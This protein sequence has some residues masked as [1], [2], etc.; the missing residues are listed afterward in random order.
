MASPKVSVII[1]SYNCE[2]FIEETIRSVIAQTF[3]DWELIVVDD[4]STDG[5][6]EKVNTINDTRVRMIKL[7]ENSGR[8]AVP[9][10]AGIRN[11]RGDY[12]AFLDHDDIWFPEKLEKQVGFMEKNTDVF[13]IYSKC[14]VLK[15]GKVISVAPRNPKS[16][17]IF[18]E[19]YLAY[20]MM[21]CSTVMMR[22]SKSGKEYLFNEDRSLMAAED[23]DL[24]LSIAYTEKV[25]FI[26]EPLAVY[27]LHSKNASYGF[28][29]FF[30]R[31]MVV[32]KKYGR[33]VPKDVLIRKYLSF[34]YHLFRNYMR[35]LIHRIPDDAI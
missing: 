4:C 26:D 20:N 6:R 5:T 34:Y 28:L 35:L 19:L 1:G 21:P 22:S 33:V 23:Y 12:I 24:W 7:D 31:V 3:K 10:N 25:S 9:R 27:R 11:S 29:P 16:G 18:N 30:K 14:L 15:D 32:M 2:K 13:L 17:R 8:P